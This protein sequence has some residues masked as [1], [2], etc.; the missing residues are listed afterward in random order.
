[1]IYF[2]RPCFFIKLDEEVWLDM[3]RYTLMREDLSRYVCV[4]QLIPQKQNNDI[5]SR[6]G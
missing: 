1:M 5:L 6:R 3:K 4:F 2:E